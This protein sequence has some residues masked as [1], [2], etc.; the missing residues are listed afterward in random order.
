MRRRRSDEAA[1]RSGKGGG[2]E[3][4]A[5]LP[6]PKEDQVV[7]G[8]WRV[9][10]KLGAGSFGAVV[11][12]VDLD[13]EQNEEPEVRAMKMEARTR[14]SQL[15]Y[16][17]RCYEQLGSV[18]GLPRVFD[19]GQTHDFS[20]LVMQHVGE[21]L[22]AM[23]ERMGG[24]IPEKAAYVVGCQAIQR[25]KDVHAKGL[26]HRDVKPQNFC[27]LDGTV[28]LCDFGLAKSY[29]DDG[30]HVPHRDGKKLTGTPRFAS[31]QTHAGVEQSRRDDLESLVYMLVYLIRGALP[32]QGLGKGKRKE[33]SGERRSDNK[34]E[35]IGKAKAE[36]AATLCDGMPALQTMFESVRR[37][38]FEQVPPYQL[39]CACLRAG[40]KRLER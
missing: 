23:Q 22:D 19:A 31:L 4:S 37:L 13:D 10:R 20:Y 16:E 9:G 26:V 18:R 11:E 17:V 8:R 3:P 15:K 7:G 25:L 38:E 29:I 2:D 1:R 32:W 30:A 36:A 14:R 39:Y 12:V 6:D 40:I 33:Q 34:S 5:P 21:P 35:R 28:Y 27:V 24:K